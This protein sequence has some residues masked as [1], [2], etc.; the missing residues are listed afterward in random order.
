MTRPIYNVELAPAAL[1]SLRKL[2]RPVQVRIAHAI[3]LL[4]ADPRPHG[5]VKLSGEDDLYRIKTGDYRII[6]SV[7]D[8]V[9]TVLV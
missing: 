2:E 5:A 4:A 8:R 7:V 3:D 1:R 9:L 6:Y